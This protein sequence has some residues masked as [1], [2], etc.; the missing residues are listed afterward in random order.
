MNAHKEP[1]AYGPDARQVLGFKAM[2]NEEGDFITPVSDK[3]TTIDHQDVLTLVEEML[4]QAGINVANRN[5][6]L[7]DNHARL[8]ARLWFEG[9]RTKAEVL[10]GD[11]LQLGLQVRNS[12]DQSS[13][14]SLSFMALR[15]LC[16]NGMTGVG[17]DGDR[18]Y[19]RHT[20]SWDTDGVRDW[21]GRGAGARGGCGGLTARISAAAPDTAARDLPSRASSA[22]IMPR[23]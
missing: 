15:L 4:A 20:G 3:Y 9:A 2:V 18:Y 7:S 19:H 14:I 5:L 6:L 21:F 12:Y 10:P 17:F 8:R 22:A 16:S 13:G 23:P 11:T 1:L